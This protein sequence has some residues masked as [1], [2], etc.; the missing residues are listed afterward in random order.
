MKKAAEKRRQNRRFLFHFFREK[1]SGLA[2]DFR[3]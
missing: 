2:W 3:V 1:Y